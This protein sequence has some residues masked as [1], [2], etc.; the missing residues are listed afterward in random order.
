MP[1]WSY[2][3]ITIPSRISSGLLEKTL[4]Y[5]ASAG[6]PDPRL[7][8]DG[9][10]N[11]ALPDFAKV[12][13]VTCRN[14]TFGTFCSFYLGVSELF[15]RNPKADFYALFQDDCICCRNIRQYLEQC[16]LPEKSYLNL[17]TYPNN[18]RKEV[19]GWSF[20]NQLGKGAVAL[21]FK[22]DVLV[23]LLRSPNWVN[24]P[25]F[26]DHPK[27]GWRKV[28]DGVIV[29]ALR[30]CNIS[31]YVHIPSLVQHDN[32]VRSSLGHVRSS[33]A[34]TFPGVDFDALSLLGA[35]NASG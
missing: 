15:L 23:D 35:A 2:G 33:Q 1:V 14:P 21:V 19:K 11:E 29:E 30:K 10:P 17:Y 5:L 32:T 7:F 13:A 6:F 16:T 27:E 34:N 22:R 24:I 25:L 28:D 26:N 4:K 9:F 8:I 20:S 12:L 18:E 3:V 31:E